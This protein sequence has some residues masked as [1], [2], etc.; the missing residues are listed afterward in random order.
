MM[1]VSGFGLKGF[2]DG[3]KDTY[4]FLN[5]IDR[6]KVADQQRADGIEYQHGRDAKNDARAE[7][8]FGLQV[9]ADNRAQ[10][11]SDNAQN[12]FDWEAKQRPHKE[13]V[14]KLQEQAA[15]LQNSNAQ[16]T[17]EFQ[18][19]TNP[20]RKSALKNQLEQSNLQLDSLKRAAKA[21]TDKI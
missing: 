19:E 6:Q 18:K 7:K 12:A 14:M 11:T 8:S 16:M 4:S 1:G 17:Y 13:A 21:S 15:K 9:T 5:N 3:M 10:R 2:V 20:D